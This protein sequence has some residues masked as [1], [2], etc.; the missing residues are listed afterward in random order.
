MKAVGP[1][2]NVT[3]ARM[4]RLAKRYGIKTGQ[5]GGQS[6]V[7]YPSGACLLQFSLE[8]ERHYLHLGTMVR[9]YKGSRE[10]YE[11]KL[12]RVMNRLGVQ[13]YDYDW[14][15]RGCWVQMVYAGRAYRFENSVD[16]SAESGRLSN[17]TDLFAQIVLALEGLARA[18]ENGIFTLDMLM[19]GVPALSAAAD[20]PDCFKAMGFERLPEDADSVKAKYRELAK[21]A[22]PDAGGDEEA[23]LLLRANLNKCLTWLAENGRAG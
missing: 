20:I 3:P 2:L 21:N 1:V 22:H 9:K 11:Q 15:R 7:R 16:K 18:I 10:E 12:G 13:V 6:F 5:R 17:V 14:S 8:G 19:A 4:L 23:F